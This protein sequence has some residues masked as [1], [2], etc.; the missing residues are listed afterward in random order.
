[1]HEISLVESVLELI[2]ESARREGFKHVKTVVL[3]IGQL[4]AVEP[5]AL[6][7]CFDVVMR[8]SI[9]EG[10][11]LEVIEKPGLARCRTCD[12]D[13]EIANREAQC[14]TCGGYA[15]QITGG[16]EMRVKALDVE[17]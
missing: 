2:E 8:G 10:A 1:M 5:E 9:A 7:F 16:T 4:A 15:L 13:V 14:P 12:K 17:S 3:E 6:E 11:R